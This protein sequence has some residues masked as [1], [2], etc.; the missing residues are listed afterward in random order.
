MSFPFSDYDNVL[1]EARGIIEDR[2]KKG[3]NRHVSFYETRCHGPQDISG[4]LWQR[5]TRILGAEQSGDVL[6]L[7]QDAID[8]VNEAIFLVMFLDRQ[9]TAQG[10]PL[11]PDSCRRGVDASPSGP[12]QGSPHCSHR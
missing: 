7:R 8:L 12:E 10:P 3:R 6:T 2:V 5:I 4:E 11:L 9:P 1:A